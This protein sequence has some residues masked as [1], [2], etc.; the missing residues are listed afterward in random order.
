[1]RWFTTSQ[2]LP[3]TLPNLIIIGAQ[4]CGT[5]SL[6][7]YLSLHPQVRMSQMKELNFFCAEGI[8]RRN[9]HRGVEWYKSNFTGRA[10]IYGESS[11]NYTSHPFIPGVPERMYSVVPE[12]KLIYLVRD[13]IER[14]ISGYLN[15]YADRREDRSLAEALADFEASDYLLRSK[16]YMQLERYLAYFPRSQLFVLTQEAL[17]ARRRET[18]RQVFRFLGV[19]E[20]FYSW[21]FDHVKHLS[22]E[23]RRKTSLAVALSRPASRLI[24]RLPSRMQRP[25]R[26][27][28]Y[29]WPLGRLVAAKRPVLDP[30][31]RRELIDRLS[32]DVRR[33]R[34]FTGYALEGW[35][36]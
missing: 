12:A 3:G 34:E 16:Y 22:S 2:S 14:M 32:D 13:P 35:C 17:Y 21:R 29:M 8:K 30:T 6:H 4:K 25:A 36:A 31:L 15:R 20:D 24:E 28:L 18:L 27:M 9:W 11:P 23:K 10:T 1:M 7:H 26:L 33:L 19:D 5:T